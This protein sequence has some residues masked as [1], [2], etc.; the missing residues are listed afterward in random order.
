MR[1]TLGGRVIRKRIVAVAHEILRIVWFMLKRNEPYRGERRGLSWRK[2][3]R[4]ECVTKWLSGVM[5]WLLGVLGALLE[6]FP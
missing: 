2:L 3:K 1:D 6:R 5:G 4:L